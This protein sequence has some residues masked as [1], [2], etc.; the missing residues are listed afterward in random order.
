M[1]KSQFLAKKNPTTQQQTP[2]TKKENREFPSWFSGNE[3]D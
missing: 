3:P 2:E 1:L